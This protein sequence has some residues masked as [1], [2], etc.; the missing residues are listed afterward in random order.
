M[1]KE[2]FGVF[3]A[4]ALDDSDED[5]PEAPRLSKAQMPKEIA[6]LSNDQMR[7]L[8]FK[9]L[10]DVPE[11]E[12][13]MKNEIEKAQ[14]RKSK[15]KPPA[16]RRIKRPSQSPSGKDHIPSMPQSLR[17]TGTTPRD[18]LNWRSIHL[19]NH[20]TFGPRSILA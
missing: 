1:M 6:S 20:L 13:V 15:T 5:E 17:I 7:K 2:F 9:L 4:Y 10:A 18:R 11:V 19:Q 8:L 14:G 3:D 16:H 12:D